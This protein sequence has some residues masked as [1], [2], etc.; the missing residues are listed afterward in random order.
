MRETLRILV[1]AD[2][3]PDVDSG[4]AGTVLETN[5]ALA[6]L[7]HS[8]DAFWADALGRRI[9]HGNLHYLVELPLAYRR[10]VAQRRAQ[11][12]FDVVQLSQPHAYLAGRAVLESADRPLMVWRSHGLEAKVE[13]AISLFSPRRTGLRGMLQRIMSNRMRSA[14]RNAMRFSDGAIVPCEDDRQYLI[15]HLGARPDRVRVIWHG[16]PDRFIDESVDEASGRWS[17]LLHVSQLSANKGPAVMHEVANEVLTACPGV[18]MTWVCPESMHGQIRRDLSPGVVQRVELKPWVSR[19]T[20]MNLYDG[21]GIFLFPTLAEGAAKVVMEAMARGMCVVSSSTS[22][23]RDY[24]RDGENGALVPVGD[25]SAMSR[26][27]VDLLRNEDRC[28]RMGGEARKTATRFRWVNCARSM[29]DFYRELD[30]MRTRST[31]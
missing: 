17:R 3:H 6:K 23:P 14:Q 30:V 9:S 24:I 8:V 16:V 12:R 5:A 18:T 2:V 10:V 1:G 7:G 11:A 29:V 22:G 4:A 28:R 26:T 15:E 13:D 21:H 19:D 27:A 20:L 25:A 31:P